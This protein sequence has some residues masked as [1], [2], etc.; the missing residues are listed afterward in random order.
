M[1]SKPQKLVA[2]FVGTFALIFFGAGSICA[3]QYLR[4]SS[5]GQIGLGLL[6]IALAYGLAM[7][8]MV[9]SL[10]HVSG[11]HFNPAITIG[12]WVTRKLSTFDAV[13]YWIAQLAGGVS[14]AY[15]L[16]QLPVDVWGPVQLGTPDL[17]NGISRTNGIIF[18]AIMTFFLVFVVFATAVD[19][20][21][22]FDKVAGFTIGL[23]ITMGSLF[24]EPFTGAALNPARAFGPAL[25]ANH[26]TNHGVYWIGPMTGGVA[27]GWLYD[28]LYLSKK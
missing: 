16:R 17:A 25:A 7:G 18:E 28:V 23:T 22:V 12:F 21:G 9:T 6:G 14:A 8:I 5:N 26:W 11:G 2:E 13:A 27:A 1:Y 15:V 24:G 10:G 4:T 3:D 20:R 19:E